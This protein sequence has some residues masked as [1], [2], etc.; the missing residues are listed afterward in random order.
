MKYI[1]AF[2]E[3]KDIG[4]YVICEE[5]DSSVDNFE[6]E[7]FINNNI[8]QVVDHRTKNNMNVAYDGVP[9]IYNIFVQYE[10]LPNEIEYDFEYHKHIK[11]CRIF[12]LEEI[13]HSSKNK[14]DLE[15]IL[16]SKKY[17]L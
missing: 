6:I 17:N 16:I 2:E 4:N 11:N 8:G 12:R 9:S 7:S 14:K 5:K 10:N 3:L 1:K 13:K 15:S